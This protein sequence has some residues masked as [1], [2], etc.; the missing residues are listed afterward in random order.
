MFKRLRA[1]LDKTSKK[2]LLPLWFIGGFMFILAAVY[3][4]IGIMMLI[5]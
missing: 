5:K 4:V 2:T 3:L 1:F